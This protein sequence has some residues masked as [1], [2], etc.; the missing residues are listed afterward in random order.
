MLECSPYSA[1]ELQKH[2]DLIIMSK[3]ANKHQRMSVGGR[4]VSRVKSYAAFVTEWS[5]GHHLFI[6]SHIKI[7]DITQNV[8]KYEN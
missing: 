6:A 7:D 5:S 4:Y 2:S 1:K 3:H 8:V